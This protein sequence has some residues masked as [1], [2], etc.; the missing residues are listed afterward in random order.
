MLGIVLQNPLSLRYNAGA[1]HLRFVLDQTAKSISFKRLHLLQS[2]PPLF[3][4]LVLS[5][6]GAS[7]SI[8]L[9]AT[10]KPNAVVSLFYSYGFSEDQVELI[11][12]KNSKLLSS[13]PER[14]IKPKLDYLLHF[15]YSQSELVALVSSD[16]HL[17]GVSLEK[18]I[19]HNLNLL[20]Q[21]LGTE[22]LVKRAVARFSRLSRYNLEKC[23]VPN[24]EALRMHGVPDKRIIQA[25]ASFPRVMTHKPDSI[26]NVAMELKELGIDPSTRAFIVGI[27]AKIAMTQSVWDSKEAI[28]KSFGWSDEDFMSAFK[29]HPY[30]M[31]N[32][33]G[34]I[35]KMMHFYVHKLGWDPAFLSKNPLLI[36]LSLERRVLPRCAVLNILASRR[37]LGREATLL[38]LLLL[39]ER[40]FEANYV[41]KYSKDITVTREAFEGMIEEDFTALRAWDERIRKNEN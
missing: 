16:P 26:S 33:E 23:I 35:K 24:V 31:L 5:S 3:R 41:V 10:E 25:V 11:M 30:C 22:E 2:I 20:K 21:L 29:R 12:E 40:S 27:N 28:Y 14:T 37:L 1:A 13:S 8:D 15:G 32:S 39:A 19:I 36:D 18:R 7:S 17:L 6:E 9:P 34:K 38:K 4:S